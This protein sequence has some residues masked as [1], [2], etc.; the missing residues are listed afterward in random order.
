MKEM[1]NKRVLITGGTGLL[2]KSLIDRCEGRY[3]VFATYMGDYEVSGRNL[4]AYCKAD[5]TEFSGNDRIFKDFLPEVVIHTASIGSPD[6]AERNQELTWRINVEGTENILSLCRK[7][8]SRFIYIS[9][10]GIYDGEHAPYGEEDVARPI[11]YYGVVKLE[12]EKRTLAS[13]VVSAIVRPILL[14][15]WNHSFERPNI[16]TMALEKLS[17]GEA[18]E[19]YEDVVSNPLYVEDC[20]NGILRIIERGRYGIFNLAGKDRVSIYGL[21]RKTAGVFGMDAS[22]VHPVRQGHFNELVAR[23]R[24]TSYTTEKMER[25]LMLKPSGIE[26][27][28]TR[29]KQQQPSH[30]Q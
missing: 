16:V 9:S 17:R 13:G 28:L 12:G 8:N 24:D 3:D 11:N 6:F 21:I 4:V 23:P 22:L 30:G 14:Y 2:G 26:E 15:G 1:K 25:E 19:V 18:I 29:M 5:V 7:Y 27:G 20:A 10:N